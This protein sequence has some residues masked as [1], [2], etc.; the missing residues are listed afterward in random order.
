MIMGKEKTPEPAM[1]IIGII[2]TGKDILQRTVKLLE[3]T[4]GPVELLPQSWP[5]DWSDYYESEMGSSLV[6]CF[7]VCERLIE[8]DALVELKLLTNRIERMLASSSGNRRINL[9]PG[10]LGLENFVLASTKRQPQRVY[11][12]KGIWAESTLWFINGG[13][14]PHERTYPDY[15]DEGVRAVLK[16]LR[17]AYKVRLREGHYSLMGTLDL[18]PH[19]EEDLS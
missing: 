6:R 19:L 1:V 4:L 12:R 7:L 14:V 9:D 13:F 17:E 3:S 18:K 10:L 2:H 15:R 16:P 8:R 5:F 11:L